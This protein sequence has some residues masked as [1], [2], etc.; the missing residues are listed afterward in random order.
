MT[1]GDA[2]AITGP[3]PDVALPDVA[4]TTFVLERA[5]PAGEKPALI[6]GP[7]GR[8]LTYRDLA[9]GIQLL[10]GGLGA[11]GFGRGDVFALL[12]PNV[13][14]FA[15]A[16][17]GALSAG[18]AVTT[19]N[20]LVTSD[21]LSRQ[22]RSSRA[23]FLLAHP[24]TL[25]VALAGASSSTVEEV[26]V[27]GEERAATPLASLLAKEAAGPGPPVDPGD[28]AVLPYSS[29]TTGWPKGVMLTHSNLVANLCQVEAVHHLAS[30]DTV[31]GVLPFFHIYGMTVVMN[32]ALR[33]GA[34]IVTMPRFE[35]EAFLRLLESYGVTRAHLVPPIILALARHPLVDDHD[36]SCL[37]SIM[38]GAAPLAPDRARA[39]ADRLGCIVNQGYG[40][41]E[42][43]PVTHMTPDAG[44]NKLGSIG[45]P[46]P[47]TTC[48]IVASN[49]EDVDA[50]TTG[51]IWIKGPQVMRGYLDDPAATRAALGDDGWLR[52]GDVGYADEDGYFYVVDRLKELIKYKGYQ[53]APAE[54]EAVLLTHPAVA[55][56]A[57]VA[58][59]DEEAGEVPKAFVVASGDADADEI[60]SFVAARV[61]P[62]KKVRGVEF[63]ERIP[64]SPS[65]KI[66][67]RH[68]IDAQGAAS[69][70]HEQSRQ[71][72]R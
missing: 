38:S 55:D 12:C 20:P 46:L 2:V 11:R 54:L 65:G 16:F 35:L 68:L 7:S 62:Y 45:P 34:T 42:A 44:P 43:S 17:H 47:N 9:R 14:E 37:R 36:L 50:D 53:V 19:I 6:D 61:A 51:E 63:V 10:A 27:L 18:G 41:T 56:A 69:W 29:G 21:E 66:L 72:P 70:P 24:S 40:L 26:F 13:P 23:R 32:L 1:R 57:V 67:R 71:L 31:V 39:C 22:L 64:R 8:L 48:R 3:H 33:R 5:A 15:L 60:A 49:G 58:S 25:E 59:P 4:L 28:L 30:H 52:S